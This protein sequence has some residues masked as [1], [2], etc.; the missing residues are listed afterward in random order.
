[1]AQ[2][3]IR[4]DDKVKKEADTL[5]EELGLNMST[6][7]NIFVKQALRERALP[8][9]VTANRS[10]NDREFY[11][12]TNMAF[13]RESLKQIEAGETVTVPLSEILANT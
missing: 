4:M 2:V 11:S 13:L 10:D 12:E 3:N 6:A 9:F 8:F 7:V 1:M 5:F